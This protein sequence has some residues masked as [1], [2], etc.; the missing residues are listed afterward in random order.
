MDVQL[1]KL[2]LLYFTG[3]RLGE[4]PRT[5]PTRSSKK[6]RSKRTRSFCCP[7]LTNNPNEVEE[8]QR[9]FDD[10]IRNHD[11]AGL[12]FGARCTRSAAAKVCGGRARSSRQHWS[13]IRNQALQIWPWPTCYVRQQNLNAA[14]KHYKRAAELSPPRSAATLRYIDFMLRTGDTAAAEKMIDDIA[15]QA[16]EYLPARVY[17][18]KFACAEKA[19]RLQQQS[20]RR[21]G[22]RPVEL[23]RFIS[24]WHAQS[25]TGRCPSRRSVSSS[26]LT[27]FNDRDPRVRYELALAYLAMTAKASPLDARNAIETAENN[28]NICAAAR[29]SI[30]GRG[31]CC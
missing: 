2:A 1:K 8:V 22:A 17:V 3:S 21:A 13:E 27:G 30:A 25:A 29:S 18:M 16:P 24:K 9:F 31:F 23:R 4:C 5:S 20:G 14:G 10:H 11:S 19:R 7:T 26:Q 15:R 6:I 28:L 12:S